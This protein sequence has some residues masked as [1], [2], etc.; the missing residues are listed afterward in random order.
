MKIIAESA[1]NHQGNIDYLKQLALK[2]KEQGAD[3]FTIQVM[4]VDTFCV[5]NY[6]KYQLYKETEFTLSKWED[7]FIFCDENNIKVIPCTLEETSFDFVY[8]LGFRLIKIHATDISNLPF[9]KKISIRNDIKVL[10]ET[11]CA[12]LFEVK[13]AIKILGEE[14]IEALF[15]GYSNYPSEVEELN[16]NVIDF[17]K[18]EFNHRVGFADHSLDTHNIPLM[19][20]AKGC[21][22][23]EKHITLSRNHRNYDWQVSLYPEEFGIMCK[24][25]KHYNLALGNKFKH[26]TKFEKS[27]RGVMYK[28]VIKG[29]NTLKRADEGLTFIENEIKDFDK[30]N[31]VVA[32]IA[33]LKSK[34]LKQKVLLPFFQNELIIDLYNKISNANFKV[35]LATSNLIEDKPLSDLFKLKVFNF[36]EGD[37]ISVIDRMLHL[38]YENKASAIFRVTGDNPFTDTDLMKEMSN[39]MIEN[40]LDYVRINNA[41]FG[42]AAELFSTKY[43]WELYLKIENPW[44]SE[45]LT[46]FVLNDDDVKIGAI[47]L[48]YSKKNKLINLSIDYPEDYDRAINLLKLLNP[49]TVDEINLKNIVRYYENFEEVDVLKEIKLP[50][51]NK[52]RLIDFLNSFNNKN[53]FTR[54]KLLIE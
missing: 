54:K 26:P 29:D 35:F 1:F 20:L 7:F 18:T 9:L 52:I 24:A 15:T 28:K 2:S 5:S 40:D 38:A 21:E 48:E 4:H 12:T 36:Y 43:L 47:D 45:Y 10:L 14:K 16:L 50:N 37:P 22:Y 3:Y 51:D 46:W 39:M 32:L 30:K 11:Q 25:I 31:H 23:I 42:V 19:I 33:R 53:Y 27:Y 17:F 49:K 41:P 44:E 34:R 13:N 6:E 8:N